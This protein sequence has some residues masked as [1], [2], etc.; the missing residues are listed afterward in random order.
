LK[1]LRG[2]HGYRS[3]ISVTSLARSALQAPL[4]GGFAAF[5]AER[6]CLSG[7]H[8]FIEAMPPTEAEP[9]RYRNASERQNLSARKAAKPLER[10]KVLMAS[11]ALTPGEGARKPDE[12]QESSHTLEFT[13]TSN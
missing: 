10:A 3:G 8:L 7:G 4:L 5:R 9:H 2:E 12:H 6:L 13:F 1:I 11:C